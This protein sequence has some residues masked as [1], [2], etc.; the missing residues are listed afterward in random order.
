MFCFVFLQNEGATTACYLSPL[1]TAVSR[2]FNNPPDTFI[3]SAAKS[4]IV[5]P[6]EVPNLPCSYDV[7][8]LRMTKVYDGQPYKEAF[9]VLHRTAT[10]CSISKME[11]KCSEV[12]FFK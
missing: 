4:P 3:M 5:Y 8:N 1:A 11:M 7:V 2:A 9:L 10:D 12:R 6:P